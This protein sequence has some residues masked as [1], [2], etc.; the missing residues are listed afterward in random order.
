VPL[1]GLVMVWLLVP[2]AVVTGSM[3]VGWWA[4][5]GRPKIT[6]LA[7]APG[8]Q[9][10][11]GAAPTG[12]D[13]GG[14]PEQGDGQARTNRSDLPK[15]PD[16]VKGRMTVQQLLD[17]FPQVTD[18]QLFARFG[19]PA[20][21]PTSIELKELAERGNGFDLPALRAWLKQRR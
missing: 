15:T 13:G 2:T 7:T 3:A 19:V 1:I 5:T 12:A 21:T 14:Q 20:D 16:D 6:A 9:E 8:S 18:E 10:H 4:T 11:T 17:A